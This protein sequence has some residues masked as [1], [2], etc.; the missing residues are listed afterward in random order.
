M[1]LAPLQRSSLEA[2]SEGGSSFTNSPC[3]SMGSI[4]GLIM[5]AQLHQGFQLQQAGPGYAPSSNALAGPGYAP[6]GNALD[7]A[8]TSAGQKA[9]SSGAAASVSAARGSET[10]AV[11]AV[12]CSGELSCQSS[13]AVSVSAMSELQLQSSALRVSTGPS[14][15]TTA[16]T[17]SR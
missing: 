12:I 13:H 2:G 11:P 14:G 9:A 1:R 3:S 8:V 17:V 15:R 16:R 5:A 4:T 7:A 6:P 10:G